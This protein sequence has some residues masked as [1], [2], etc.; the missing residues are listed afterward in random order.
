MIYKE[1]GY[2]VR[3]LKDEG[4][5][6]IDK[7]TEEDGSIYYDVYDRDDNLQNS[8]RTAKDAREW[9]RMMSK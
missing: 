6:T 9:A 7:V 4:D 1:D 3:P 5:F 8:F 2:T